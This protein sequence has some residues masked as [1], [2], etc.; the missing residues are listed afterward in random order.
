[1]HLQKYFSIPYYSLTY[2]YLH[3]EIFI[4]DVPTEL[5]QK[6]RP[7]KVLGKCCSVLICIYISFFKKSITNFMLHSPAVC[8]SL[9]WHVPPL[10]LCRSRDPPSHPRRVHGWWSREDA[11]LHEPA[12]T[13]S[14]PQSVNPEE[15]GKWLI[16]FI[17][18]PMQYTDKMKSM[19]FI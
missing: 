17:Q 5:G 3:N 2:H 7:L 12:S 8:I 13:T 10:G 18:H 16:A 9:F 15:R 14:D 6:S 19:N 1:M 4:T 11:E